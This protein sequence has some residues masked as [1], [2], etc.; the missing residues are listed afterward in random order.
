MASPERRRRRT[1]AED[2]DE[3]EARGTGLPSPSAAPA[4]LGAQQQQPQQQQ[5]Q[6]QQQQS[7]QPARHQGGPQSHSGDDLRRQASRLVETI[8][9][10]ER[11]ALLQALLQPEPVLGPGSAGG[12]T[13]PAVPGA[14]SASRSADI[15]QTGT[16][17]PAWPPQG[18]LGPGIL[19]S[20]GS[21][22]SEPNGGASFFPSRGARAEAG[23]YM[24]G[25]WA[26]AQQPPFPDPPGTAFPPQGLFWPELAPTA[27]G[28]TDKGTPPGHTA[29]GETFP[30]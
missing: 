22:G 3:E 7:Q 14:W 9:P 29:P 19:G 13:I 23:T 11:E 6:Q 18:P 8:S 25:G 26:G 16:G 4:A 12:P 17:R 1:A 10:A 2:E 27:A 21:T 15:G 5:Q 20:A 24:A 30:L 28:P